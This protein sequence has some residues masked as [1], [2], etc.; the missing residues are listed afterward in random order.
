MAASYTTTIN[1]KKFYVLPTECICVFCKLFRTETVSIQ[2]I[3]VLVF[4][5]E[6]ES[7]YCAVRA[8]LWTQFKLIAIFQ[9]LIYATLWK[10]PQKFKRSSSKQNTHPC[11]VSERQSRALKEELVSRPTLCPFY[12]RTKS[13]WYPHYAG[14][15][16]PVAQPITSHF[17]DR[18]IMPA[19]PHRIRHSK[20][21]TIT[22]AE[23]NS[24]G[25]NW[26]TSSLADCLQ[27]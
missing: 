2:S 24:I 4:I 27:W 17:S 20:L 16:T 23:S 9:A 10:L 15:R 8:D 14:N 22:S 1:I 19:V 11:S 26:T 3:N 25:K 12:S 5:P 6:T 13:S 21:V 18:D 7:V